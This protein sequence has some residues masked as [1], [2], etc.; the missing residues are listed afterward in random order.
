MFKRCY[1]FEVTSKH[2]RFITKEKGELIFLIGARKLDFLLKELDIQ[3]ISV[4]K[5]SI[6]FFFLKIVQ[7]IYFFF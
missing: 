2:N 3:S 1:F 6:N 4:S 7:I 5:H